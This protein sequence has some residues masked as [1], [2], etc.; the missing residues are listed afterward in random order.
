L[1]I[2]RRNHQVTIQHQ[3][4]KRS[5][6]PVY[7]NIIDVEPQVYDLLVYLVENRDRVVSKNDLIASV[8]GGRNRPLRP[9]LPLP[10]RPAIAG[11]A[12]RQHE[13]RS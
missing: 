1:A 7:I 6:L 5:F 9:P 13:R 4:D 11:A 12:L 2:L 8:W 3:Y 10:D